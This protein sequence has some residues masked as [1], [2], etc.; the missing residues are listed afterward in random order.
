MRRWMAALAVV[1]GLAGTPA[2]AQYTAPGGQSY[3][4]TGAG[5][6][7]PMYGPQTG[8]MPMAAPPTAAATQQVA[9]ATQAT[10]LPTDD[11]SCLQQMASTVGPLLQQASQFSP[12]G[13]GGNYGPLAYPFAPGPGFGGS[14]PVA[15]YNN[16]AALTQGASM[17]P[18]GLTAPYIANLAVTASRFNPLFP[19]PFDHNA[20]DTRT[21]IDLA[22]LQQTEQSRLL[23]QALLTQQQGLY[24]NSL[25]ALSSS[26]QV[27]ASDWQTSYSVL[28]QAWM[29]Y[30]RDLC[31]N[32]SNG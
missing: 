26:Y 4:M 17:L 18:P 27:A 22:N 30:Y 16:S 13:M 29:N 7:A 8:R 25:Y 3:P 6:C 14:L 23:T 15:A 5:C 2:Y 32:R 20:P 19:N 21:L 10:P 1:A 31:R 9:A 28:A 11:A 24:L 12:A